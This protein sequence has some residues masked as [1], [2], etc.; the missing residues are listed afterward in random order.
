MPAGPPVSQRVWAPVPVALPPWG[1]G[2]TC[3]QSA[4]LPS[5]RRAGPTTCSHGKGVTAGTGPTLT[6]ASCA[7]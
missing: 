4:Q 3:M 2:L 1:F 7:W 5:C 6:A